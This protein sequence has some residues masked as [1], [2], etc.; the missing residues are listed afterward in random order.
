MKVSDYLRVPYVVTAQSRPLRDGS[1]YVEHP[2]LPDCSVDAESISEALQLLDGRRIEVV[3]RMLSDG[4]KPPM[5][6]ALLG[7][8]QARRRVE[9]AGLDA[10]IGPVWTLDVDDLANRER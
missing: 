2:E 9:R 4:L 8:T 10:L 3:M 7:E 6:K 5:R 1:C